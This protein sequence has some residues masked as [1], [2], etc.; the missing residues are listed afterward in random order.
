M[1]ASCEGV[2]VE[3][4]EACMQGLATSPTTIGAPCNVDLRTV[5]GCATTP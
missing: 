1:S 4:L 5:E 3:N 2:L